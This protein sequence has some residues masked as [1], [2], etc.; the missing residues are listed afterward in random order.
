MLICL[1][2]IRQSESLSVN[3]KTALNQVADS[4]P[5]LKTLNNRPW[6]A[7]SSL[8]GCQWAGVTCVNDLVS[9]LDLTGLGLSG[10]APDSLCNLQN[11]TEIYFSGNSI[12]CTP[13]NKR[14]FV[15]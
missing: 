2:W 8:D 15:D 10:A 13:L 14:K 6:S 5:Q 1:L 11:L 4:I 12:D 3:D 7:I 9:V